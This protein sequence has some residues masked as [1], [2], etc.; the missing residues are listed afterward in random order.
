VVKIGNFILPSMCNLEKTNKQRGI[1]TI[2][3]I[4]LKIFTIM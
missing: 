1:D 3:R 2:L 4:I